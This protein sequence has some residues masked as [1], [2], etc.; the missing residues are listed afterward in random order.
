[1]FL[2]SGFCLALVARVCCWLFFVFVCLKFQIIRF[3]ISTLRQYSPSKYPF[4]PPRKHSVHHGSRLERCCHCLLPLQRLECV[5][6]PQDRVLRDHGRVHRSRSQVGL[7]SIVL[8]RNSPFPSWHYLPPWPPRVLVEKMGPAEG[9][10]MATT[11]VLAADAVN[12]WGGIISEGGG[13]P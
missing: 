2:S 11:P 8:S 9:K 3:V 6:Q 10:A 4:T 1:M 12:R 13:V 7:A 5:L